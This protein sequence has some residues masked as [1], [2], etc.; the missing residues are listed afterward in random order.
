MTAIR[1]AGGITIGQDE[2]TYTV[3]GMHRACADHRVLQ[4]VVALQQVSA[5]ILS[6]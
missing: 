6:D 2:V 1:D 3:Y 4:K 5:Q